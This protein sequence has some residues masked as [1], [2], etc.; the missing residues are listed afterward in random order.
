MDYYK[1]KPSNYHENKNKYL[2]K[3]K[4]DLEFVVGLNLCL[5]KD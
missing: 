4:I 2:N 3:V 1:N 5:Q